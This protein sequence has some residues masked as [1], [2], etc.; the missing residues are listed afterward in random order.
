MDHSRNRDHSKKPEQ[1]R[2]PEG[3]NNRLNIN[4]RRKYKRRGTGDSSGSLSEHKGASTDDEVLM[5]DSEHELSTYGSDGEIDEETGL[6]TKERQKYLK[7]KR[8]HDGLDAR[9]G[10]TGGIS[11]E[12]AREADRN[13]KRKLLTNAILI[14]LWYFFSLSISIVSNYPRLVGRY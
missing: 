5:T 10:G 8:R 3:Q 1:G 6:T 7:N 11:K 2:A 14:G 13:V 9:I 4:P 12:E